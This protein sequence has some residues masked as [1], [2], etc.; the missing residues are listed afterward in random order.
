MLQDLPFYDS[1]NMRHYFL[2]IVVAA[3]SLIATD[4]KAGR[5]DF[6]MGVAAAA[7]AMLDAGY[8]Q[9]RVERVLNLLERQIIAS[10]I[11]SKQQSQ[12]AKGFNYQAT[13]NRCKL[14]Y[15]Y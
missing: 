3:A 6:G 15:R 10:G 13:R 2:V 1:R 9:A 8:S 12:M 7:C 5:G 14:R 11:S 4:A